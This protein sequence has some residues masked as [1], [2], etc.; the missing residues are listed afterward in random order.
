[1]RITI[2]SYLAEYFATLL[3]ILSALVSGGNPLIIGATLG[4]IVLLAGEI[5]GGMANPAAALANFMNGTL[6]TKDV[7]IYIFVQLFGGA[8]G[9]YAY[10]MLKA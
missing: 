2:A 3:L 4:L 7:F 8:S 10:K 5:S 9:F 1:M 6:T